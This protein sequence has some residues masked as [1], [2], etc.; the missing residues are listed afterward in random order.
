MISTSR[1]TGKRSGKRPVIPADSDSSEKEYWIGPGR[2]PKEYQFKPGQSGNPKGA[3][4]KSQSI[5]PDLKAL[6]EHALSKTVTLRQGEKEKIVTQA[7]AGI[8][9]L[10]NQFAKGDRYARRD[11]IDL[12]NRLG[13]DLVTGQGKRIEEA[14]QT[15]VGPHDIALVAD[16]LKRHGG[17]PDHLDDDLGPLQENLPKKSTHTNPGRRQND[18]TL[19]R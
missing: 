16:F 6:L 1:L 13:V 3:R 11:V 2:P 10:V 15:D 14:L 12:A 7:E 4:R 19:H 18:D 5:A 17:N 9:H 8:E